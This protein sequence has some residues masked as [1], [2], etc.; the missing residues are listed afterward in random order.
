MC[1]S[2][3]GAC[4]SVARVHVS[5]SAAGRR[6]IHCVFV[7]LP[8]D[9]AGTAAVAV[10]VVST[11]RCVWTRGAPKRKVGQSERTSEVAATDWMKRSYCGASCYTTIFVSSV[12]THLDLEGDNIVFAIVGLVKFPSKSVSTR[13]ALTHL[14]RKL[15]HSWD[16]REEDQLRT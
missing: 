8:L 1:S 13:R 2:S 12:F 7:Y 14:S 16:Q 11:R 10:H 5:R 15:I 3:A 9:V 4:S 6:P